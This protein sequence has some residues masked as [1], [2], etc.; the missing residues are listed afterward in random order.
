MRVGGWLPWRRWTGV[1]GPA[2]AFLLLNIGVYAYLGGSTGG[3]AAGLQK[4]VERLEAECASL[5]HTEALVTKERNEL[6][7]LKRQLEHLNRDVFGSLEQR[8]TR[9]LREVETATRAAGLR[10]ARFSYDAKEDEK[11]GLTRFGVRFSV[12]GTFRQIETLLESLQES[13]EFLIVDRLSLSGEKGN[14]STS[15]KISIHVAT[16]LVEADRELL[17]RLVRTP[18]GERKEGAGGSD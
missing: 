13:E 12:E 3:R 10:P 18:D 11:S 5:R 17:Q 14:R 8:L 4:D 7:E 16:Y 1:W 9:I 2:M 6:Q 15:L